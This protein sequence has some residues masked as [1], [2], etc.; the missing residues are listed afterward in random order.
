MHAEIKQR[1]DNAIKHD[2]QK[3]NSTEYEFWK[4]LTDTHLKPTSEAF[5]LL[6][7]LKSK[8]LPL[9]NDMFVFIIAAVFFVYF[10]CTTKICIGF[11]TPLSTVRGGLGSLFHVKPC[12]IMYVCACPKSLVQWLF[13]CYIFVFCSFLYIYLRNFFRLKYLIYVISS[14]R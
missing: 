9:N 5:S 14:F 3:I 4:L 13:L 6:G 8:R 2:I 10:L 12:H 7:Q 11:S 1:L